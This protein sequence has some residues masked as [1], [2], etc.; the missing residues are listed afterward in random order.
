MADRAPKRARADSTAETTVVPSDLTRSPKLL[1]ML[2][3]MNEKTVFNLLLAAAQEFPSVAALV[4]AEYARLAKIENEKTIDFS[5]HSKSVWRILN[6][7]YVKGIKS[8]R[9]F[10]MSQDAFLEVI[11]KISDI[12]NRCPQH[13]S[14]GTKFNALESLRKIGKVICMSDSSELMREVR[15]SFSSDTSL[16]DTM[17]DIL[18]TMN[19]EQWERFLNED[20]DDVAWTERLEELADMAADWGIFE[21][22]KAVVELLSNDDDPDDDD[23]DYSGGDGNESGTN[24]NHNGPEI[25]DMTSP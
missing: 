19:Q 11:D 22:L 2:E 5:Q 18:N 20:V 10:E 7:E 13:A 25:I 14:Y 3:S 23:D 24:V 1:T 21:G 6:V 4:E 9:Q 12:E 17:M 8:S 16:E 15:K